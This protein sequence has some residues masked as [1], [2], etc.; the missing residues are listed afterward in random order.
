MPQNEYFKKKY[1]PQKADFSA[2]AK[3]GAIPKGSASP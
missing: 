1:T 3:K 2:K